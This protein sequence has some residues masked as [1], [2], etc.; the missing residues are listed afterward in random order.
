VNVS[1]RPCFYSNSIFIRTHHSQKQE[2]FD[3]A[4]CH[5]WVCDVALEPLPPAVPLVDYATMVFVLSAMAH[6]QMPGVVRKIYDQLKPGGYLFFRD[7]ARFDL[8]QLRFKSGCKLNDDCYARWDGTLTSFVT[9]EQIDVMFEEAG[10]VVL[11]NLYHRKSITNRKR[12][13]EMRR[14]WLQCRAYKPL[15]AA[16]FAALNSEAAR[17]ERRAAAERKIADA[18]ARLA[19]TEHGD[20]ETAAAAAVVDGVSDVADAAAAANGQ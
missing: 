5:V 10:F 18:V 16:D 17:A 3:A 20:N 4:R 7:Y 11:E 13:V 1:R 6:E 12:G 19:A 2:R 14:C 8:T 9:R 15:D